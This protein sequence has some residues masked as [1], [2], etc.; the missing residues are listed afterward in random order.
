MSR[1]RSAGSTSTLAALACSPPRLRRGGGGRGRDRRP[2]KVTLTR[3]TPRA[4]T[5]SSTSSPAT[6]SRRTDRRA[7][8]SSSTS[9]ARAQRRPR[10]RR[11]RRRRPRFRRA[12]RGDLRRGA[13]LLHGELGFRP[14]S[15]TRHPRQRRR[16]RFDVYLVDFA[17]TGDGTFQIDADGCSVANPEVCTGYMVQRTIRR[18]R[19]SS[20]AIANRILGSHELF[21]AVQAAYDQGQGPSSPRGRRVGHRAVRSGA[22]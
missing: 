2:G 12:G 8:A 15:A 4:T 16:C 22:R 14:P 5:S 10:R 20:T 6:S 9:P 18:V 1:T 7:A 3:R 17:G 19:L 11:R 21:H 13:G